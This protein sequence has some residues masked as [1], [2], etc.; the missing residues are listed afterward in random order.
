MRRRT[1]RRP[2]NAIFFLDDL[3]FF[4]TFGPIVKKKNSGY[5][6]IFFLTL[7]FFMTPDSITK[8]QITGM[9]FFLDDSFFS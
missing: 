2:P 4:L 1:A 9:I 3:C 7:Y 6:L 5:G 8:K